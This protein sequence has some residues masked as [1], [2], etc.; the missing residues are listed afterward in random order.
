MQYTQKEERNR[1]KNI[2]L[3]K[4]RKKKEERKESSVVESIG[5]NLEIW[6]H[7]VKVEREDV[8]ENRRERE[9]GREEKREDVD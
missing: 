6:I 4:E 9:R 5:C 1:K 8:S 2:N 3:H 7:F